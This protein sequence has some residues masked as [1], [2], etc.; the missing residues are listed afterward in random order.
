[1]C[2]APNNRIASRFWA[3]SQRFD[4]LQKLLESNIPIYLYISDLIRAHQD[5]T[6][7]KM[8]KNAFTINLYESEFVQQTVKRELRSK[9]LTDSLCTYDIDMIAKFIPSTV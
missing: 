3:G 7:G 4:L 6:S 2:F 1:M 9:S 8:C 5:E